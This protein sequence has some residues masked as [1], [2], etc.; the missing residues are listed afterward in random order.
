VGATD[1]VIENLWNAPRTQLK[2]TPPT[3]GGNCHCAL[4]EGYLI[5]LKRPNDPKNWQATAPGRCTAAELEPLNPTCERLWSTA[6]GSRSRKPPPS[7]TAMTYSLMSAVDQTTRRL[8]KKTLHGAREIGIG[9]TPVAA[10]S[11]VPAALALA[12]NPH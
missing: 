6:T 5:E 3:C 8:L 11:P 1:V 12:R 7:A 10:A 4:R 9:P 2:T